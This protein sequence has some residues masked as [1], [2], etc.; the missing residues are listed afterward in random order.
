VKANEATLLFFASFVFN[1]S[2]LDFIASGLF[3]PL[4]ADI[5]DGERFTQLLS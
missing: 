2:F 3:S 5:P 1:G 4:H